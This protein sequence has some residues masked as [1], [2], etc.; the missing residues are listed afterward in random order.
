V[1]KQKEA[2]KAKVLKTTGEVGERSWKRVIETYLLLWNQKTKRIKQ[3][4]LTLRNHLCRRLE[5]TYA[6]A[7][8][9]WL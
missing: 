5:S 4:K 2:R 6:S 9:S 3:A 8:Q 7:F 1:W